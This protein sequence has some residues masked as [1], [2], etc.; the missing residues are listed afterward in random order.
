MT[1]TSRDSGKTNMSFQ[2]T[3]RSRKGKGS[4]YAAATH[5]TNVEI[6]NVPIMIRLPHHAAQQRQ[7][8]SRDHNQT[9]DNGDRG[10]T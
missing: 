1:D 3:C 6:E 7:K 10:K 5:D 9:G 4:G 2:H 8:V